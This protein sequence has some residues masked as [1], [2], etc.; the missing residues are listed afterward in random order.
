MMQQ[1]P[2]QWIVVDEGPFT[3][4][5]FGTGNETGLLVNMQGYLGKKRILSGEKNLDPE[6]IL[7]HVNPNAV[8]LPNCSYLE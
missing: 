1:P 2:F 6:T 8:R 7:K 4:L 5:P 3:K